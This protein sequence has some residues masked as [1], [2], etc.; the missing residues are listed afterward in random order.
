MID[1]TP[2]SWRAWY[3][4]GRQFD[5]TTTA[6]EDLPAEGLLRVN[7]YYRTRPYYKRLHGRSL[8]WLEY[9]DH[10]PVY[11]YD[12]TADAIISE[13]ARENNRVKRGKWIADAEWERIRLLADAAVTAPN[14]DER[15]DREP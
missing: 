7:V 3:T 11:C 2:C 4:G 6:W 1:M 10:G 9:T 13:E 5:S 15:V 14:E 12:D 8:Y